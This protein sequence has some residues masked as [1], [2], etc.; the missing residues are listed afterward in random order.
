MITTYFTWQVWVKV[1]GSKVNGVCGGTEARDRKGLNVGGTTKVSDYW[2]SCPEISCSLS[3][4]EKGL[5]RGRPGP[6]IYA[7]GDNE[8]ENKRVL[9]SKGSPWPRITQPKACRAPSLVERGGFQGQWSAHR[10]QHG[11]AIMIRMSVWGQVFVLEATKCSSER[12]E[13][14]VLS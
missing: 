3:V 7:G 6:T 11:T 2:G 1:T 5:Q 13:T 12:S 8:S 9:F 10:A 4:E 14:G